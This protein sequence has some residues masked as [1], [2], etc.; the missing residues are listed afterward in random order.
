ML[1]RAAP[2]ALLAL[3][4]S[5]LA[6]CPQPTLPLLALGRTGD[7]QVVVHLRLCKEYRPGLQ[8]RTDPPDRF[9][10]ILWRIHR[11][12]PSREAET[13]VLGVVPAG[14]TAEAPQPQ[15]SQSQASPSA[16]PRPAGKLELQ[17]GAAYRIDVFASPPATPLH[18]T[19]ADLEQL[20]PDQV[21]TGTVTSRAE[22]D[23]KAA[24]AC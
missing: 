12:V 8:L 16:P 20:Q 21:R 14:W 4:A 24:D 6:A 2:I 22:F 7:G 9:G 18:F 13:I 11:T 1:R 5:T 17:A 10:D 23:R 19:L 3:A 15:P